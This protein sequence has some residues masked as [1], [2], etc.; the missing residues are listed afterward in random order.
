[1]KMGLYA[2]LD[3]KLGDFGAPFVSQRDE[4]AQRSFAD[5]V[6]D[7]SNPNNQWFRHPEDFALY[8]IG[9]Y[10]TE[11]ATLVPMVLKCMVNASAL[12][13]ADPQ[14]N[15]FPNGVEKPSLVS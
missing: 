6:N 11:T 15:L 7:G 4:S 3:A 1:M 8:K 5:A 10:D 12:K 13:K 14:L 2:V 9:D